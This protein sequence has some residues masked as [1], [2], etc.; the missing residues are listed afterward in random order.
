MTSSIQ[1]TAATR[2]FESYL[3]ALRGGDRRRAFAVIDEARE[4]GM[5]VGE[6]YLEVFQAALREIGRLWQQNEI[7][8]ADE[9]LAT[10][11]TQA[12]MARLY[13]QVFSWQP[14]SG[15]TLIAACADVERHE[16]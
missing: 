9:H 12:A 6:I 8:V 5:A 10:A 2:A 11:I 7:S 3:S 16:I 13:E 14:E 15:H 1:S 4:A